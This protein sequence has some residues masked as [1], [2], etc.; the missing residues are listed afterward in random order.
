MNAGLFFDIPTNDW[1]MVSFAMDLVD[2]QIDAKRVEL[3]D[4]SFNLKFPFYKEVADIAWR[5]LVGIGFGYLGEVEPF[6]KSSYMTLKA[7]I[8]LVFYSLKKHAFIGELTAYGSPW[9]DNHGYNITSGP[10]M[11]VGMCAIY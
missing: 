7:G 5:P 9:G 1:M 4:L 11:L 6:E 3:L 2:V 8:E 10:V